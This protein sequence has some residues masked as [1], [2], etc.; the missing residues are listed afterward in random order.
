MYAGKGG[1]TTEMKR[2]SRLADLEQRNQPFRDDTAIELLRHD[3]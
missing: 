2:N 1:A 3:G